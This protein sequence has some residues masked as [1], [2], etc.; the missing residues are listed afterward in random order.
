MS[1]NIS[2]EQFVEQANNRW[3]SACNTPILGNVGMFS[4]G[5]ASPAIGGGLGM[6]L[7]FDNSELLNEF[8]VNTLPFSPPGPYDSNPFEVYESV[9]KLIKDSENNLNSY[10]Q[11]LNKILL[12]YSHIEWLVIL[13][14][15][16]PVKINFVKRLELILGKLSLN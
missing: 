13:R 11:D 3:K 5:D 2:L 7:W 4:Y 1:N 10:L 14:N 15:F 12:H 9:T 8:I 6:F 16:C